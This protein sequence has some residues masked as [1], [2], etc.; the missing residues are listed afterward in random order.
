MKIPAWDKDK[1]K[2][3]NL[4]LGLP[5]D[6]ATGNKIVVGCNY[7]TTWQT[8]RNMRFVLDDVDLEGKRAFL[9]TRTTSKSFWTRLD[10]LIYIDTGTNNRK[11][12]EFVKE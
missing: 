1:W 8:H 10:D 3:R 6:N 4:E 2:A 9:K 5:I 12:K 7:H 11:S